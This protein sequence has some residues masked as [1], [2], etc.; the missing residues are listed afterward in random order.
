[1]YGPKEIIEMESNNSGMA[2]ELFVTMAKKRSMEFWL[3]PKTKEEYLN[4][5]EACRDARSK[6]KI[7]DALI[8]IYRS[9]TIKNGG[10]YSAT[11]CDELIKIFSRH[12]GDLS[13]GEVA[14]YLLVREGSYCEGVRDFAGALKFYEKSLSYK[15]EDKD[16]QY[17]RLNNL[18]FTLNY[19][20]RFKEAEPFL[21]EAIAIDPLKYNAP[22]NLGVCLEHQQ[23]FEKAARS[24]LKSSQLCPSDGRAGLHLKRLIERHPT[25][26][27]L[28]ELAE[29]DSD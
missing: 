21:R 29:F 5:L 24:Y 10:R 13:L 14:A 26:K 4:D 1:M 7:L 28:P 25:L 6:P 15:V 17:F 23:Q 18:A 12:M 11:N 20:G 27:N 19:L 3:P 2:S 8:H 16:L 22:K 9:S